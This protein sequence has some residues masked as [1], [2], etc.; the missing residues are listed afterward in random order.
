[1]RIL[2]LT[3]YRGYRKEY[4]ATNRL[5]LV[6]QLPCESIVC[7]SPKQ[8]AEHLKDVDVLL[9]DCKDYGTGLPID[10]KALFDTFPGLIGGFYKDVWGKR[11]SF[12]D[13]LRLDMHITLFFESLISKVSRPDSWHF[14]PSCIDVYESS[15][16]R[17][18]DILVCGAVNS[19]YPFRVFCNRE[20]SKLIVGKT[21]LPDTEGVDLYKVVINGREYVYGNLTLLAARRPG[22]Y[23]PKLFD[24]LLRTKLGCTGPVVI[25]K[26]SKHCVRGSG[27][28]GPLVVGKY[29]EYA[30]AGVVT[31]STKFFDM[32]ALGFQHQENLWITDESRFIDDLVYLLEHNDVRSSISE[33]AKHLIKTRH[34]TKIRA[35][36]FYALLSSQ[37]NKH[38]E[39]LLSARV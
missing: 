24:L 22:Y 18:I 4:Q 26:L 36:E 14:V 28:F 13:D 33:N 21:S 12:P 19:T 29:F 32:Q 6:K 27:G 16:P 25:N 37:L 3:S 2:F 8:V 34:T 1:M 9:L 39:E 23:G 11:F 30:A 15:T 20:L 38:R 5:R 10:Y 35:N 31:V 17:D 7:C